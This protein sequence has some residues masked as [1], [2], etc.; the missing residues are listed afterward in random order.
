[1]PDSSIIAVIATPT[2]PDPNA[3]ATTNR[4]LLRRSRVFALNVGGGPGCGK[5]TLLDATI[6]LL[7]PSVRVGVI[8][9]DPI[10]RRDA[11]SLVRHANQVIQVH[12]GEDRPLD[13]TLAGEALSRLDLGALEIVFMENLGTLLGPVAADLG[14]DA[15]VVVFS[16]AQGEDQPAKHPHLVAVADA[17]LLNKIDLLPGS[18]FDLEA[19]RASVRRVNPTV[20]VFEVSAKD[21]EQF[22]PWARWLR[23]R[24][25]K[26]VN[27]KS[28]NHSNGSHWFG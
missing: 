26:Q 7:R 13:A 18:T 10:S 14:Q 17:V 20:P 9:A 24:V 22:E 19:F 27:E 23:S 16:V 12:T 2:P 11:E 8:A 15:T 28:P 21:G 6:D 25:Y 1:M 5:T 3:A 4:E